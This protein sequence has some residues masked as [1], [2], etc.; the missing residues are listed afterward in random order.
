MYNALHIKTSVL[1]GKKLEITSSE[2]MEGTTVEVFVVL[3]KVLKQKKRSALEVVDAFTGYSLF[4]TADEVN[5]YIQEVRN[6][7]DL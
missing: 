6:S 7:W 3:P 1:P 2:L 4:K 5:S